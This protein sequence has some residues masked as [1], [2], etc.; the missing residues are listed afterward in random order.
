MQRL[1]PSCK[2]ATELLTQREH[3]RLSLVNSVRLRWHLSGCEPCQHYV[4]QVDILTQSARSAPPVGQ[5][6]TEAQQRLR[7]ALKREMSRETD[8]EIHP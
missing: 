2:E 1:R 6:S 5:I 8:R 4:L 7:E 3:T